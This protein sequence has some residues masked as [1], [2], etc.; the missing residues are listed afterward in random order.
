MIALQRSKINIILIL[1]ALVCPI[2]VNAAGT[3]GGVILNYLPGPR[4]NAMADAGTALAGDF[5]ASSWNP[6]VLGTLKGFSISA[7]YYNAFE[8]TELNNK[9]ITAQQDLVFSLGYG[10]KLKKRLYVGLQG[11]Y[12]SSTLIEEHKATSYVMDGGLFLRTGIFKAGDQKRNKGFSSNGLDM[13]VSMLNLGQKISYSDSS[14]KDPLPLLYRGGISYPFNINRDHGVLIAGDVVGDA[15]QNIKGGTGVEY[16]NKD[17]IFARAGYRV[18]YEIKKLTWGLGFKYNKFHFDY[19]MGLNSAINS[20]HSIMMTYSAANSS[21]NGSR[22]RIRKKRSK[23][24]RVKKSIKLK[25]TKKK[26][27]RKVKKK[28]IKL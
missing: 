22:R 4:I 5:N 20:E 10:F 12:Y 15:E 14:A 7:L 26:K 2:V 6:A 28:K 21:S 19:S 25:K 11:K 27:R 8:D 23:K 3:T 16:S 9:T 18:N 13:G 17:M 1:F 24:P